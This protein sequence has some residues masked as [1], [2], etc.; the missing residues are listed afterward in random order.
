MVEA[1]VAAVVV[2]TLVQIGVGSPAA[3]HG[4]ND[5]AQVKEVRAFA[6]FV[7]TRERSP[8][9]LVTLAAMVDW[10]TPAG[11]YTLPELCRT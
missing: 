10:F 9:A 4:R 5:S 7:E 2:Q 1:H 6:Q 3:S 8:K 11:M